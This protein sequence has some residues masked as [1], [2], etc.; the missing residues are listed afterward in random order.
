M[1]I[2]DNSVSDL[3]GAGDAGAHPG[4][5]PV[6]CVAEGASE[7]V[8]V[9]QPSTPG[10]WALLTQHVVVCTLPSPPR[11]TSHLK[12][13]VLEVLKRSIKICGSDILINEPNHFL[14]VGH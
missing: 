14:S 12:P 10:A 5:P 4:S 2:L 7:L 1:R 11:H 13:L 3:P 8:R 6:P 9:P